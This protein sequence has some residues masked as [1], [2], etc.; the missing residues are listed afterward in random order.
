[1]ADAPHPERPVVVIATD[2]EF[3]IAAR[4]VLDL[5]EAPDGT[6]GYLERLAL[7]NAIEQW[8]SRQQPPE[9]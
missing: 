6:A 7:L 8:K 2:A 1:M 9:G 5:T 4:R 3:K